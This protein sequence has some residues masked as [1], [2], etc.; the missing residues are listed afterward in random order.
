MS[1]HRTSVV[2]NVASVLLSV[3]LAVV[4]GVLPENREVK[5]WLE[6][7]PW[8]SSLPLSIALA[9]LVVAISLLRF[10][11]VGRPTRTMT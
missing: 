9:S 10:G 1:H 2:S 8:Y 4:I 6:H 7:Q 5:T 11:E 3:A